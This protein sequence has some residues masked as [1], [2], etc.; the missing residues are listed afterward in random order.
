MASV[1]YQLLPP[2]THV[3]SEKKLRKPQRLG[4]RNWVTTFTGFLG[5]HRYNTLRE[6][7]K[8]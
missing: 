5:K 8:T 3:G 7:V 6:N 2:Q 1:M 4:C